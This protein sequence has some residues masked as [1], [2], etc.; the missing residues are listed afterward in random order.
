M[1]HQAGP[2]WRRKRRDVGLEDRGA[3]RQRLALSSPDIP[4]RD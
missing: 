2:L 1:S 3:E 4:E